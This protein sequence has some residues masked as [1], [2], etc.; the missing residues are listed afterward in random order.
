MLLVNKLISNFSFNDLNG[1]LWLGTHHSLY[2]LGMIFIKHW[3][4]WRLN[5]DNLGSCVLLLL[6]QF[7]LRLQIH[8]LFDDGA[9]ILINSDL[10]A[11]RGSLGHPVQRIRTHLCL[12][13]VFIR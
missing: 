1:S 9:S 7:L 11:G 8:N 4:V 12:T 13:G 10:V 5:I 6:G 2:P 3:L